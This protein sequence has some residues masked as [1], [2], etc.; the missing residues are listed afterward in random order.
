MQKAAEQQADKEAVCLL[1][2]WPPTG[3]TFPPNCLRPQATCGPQSGTRRPL[4]GGIVALLSVQWAELVFS[5]ALLVFS[6]AL[7]V[8]RVLLTSVSGE[9]RG[10]AERKWRRAVPVCRRTVCGSRQENGFWRAASGGEWR[11]AGGGLSA[12]RDRLSRFALLVGQKCAKSEEQMIADK[13]T[14]LTTVLVS[15]PPPRARLQLFLSN[16]LSLSLLRPH[17]SCSLARPKGQ[18][19]GHR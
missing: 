3:A 2:N 11:L 7:L 16:T 19:S 14:H 12:A 8:F 4:G 13:H 15:P 5:C 17:S 9:Q 10:K 18:S 6:C 1:W